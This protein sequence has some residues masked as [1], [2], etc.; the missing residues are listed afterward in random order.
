[1]QEAALH[2]HVKALPPASYATMQEDLMSTV[3]S[4]QPMQLVTV[5]RTRAHQ[6]S[7]TLSAARILTAPIVPFT[8]HLYLSFSH[9]VGHRNIRPLLCQT[10]VMSG[11]TDHHHEVLLLP[12]TDFA[13]VLARGGLLNVGLRSNALVHTVKLNWQSGEKD[14]TTEPSN[15][16][17]PRSDNFMELLMQ[18]YSWTD[19]VMLSISTAL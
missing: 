6:A 4:V 2:W 8:F 5:L 19:S 14:S 10:L 18:I 7:M 1:M 12:S 15:C 17:R 3:I 13:Q 9:T 11:S 16:K